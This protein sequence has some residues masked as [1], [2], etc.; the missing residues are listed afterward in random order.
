V[1]VVH[2][3]LLQR[4]RR[5]RRRRRKRRRRRIKKAQGETR[6]KERKKE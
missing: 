1:W 3:T 5:R 6:M 4:R 2:K